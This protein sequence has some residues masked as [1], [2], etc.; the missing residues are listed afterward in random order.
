MKVLRAIVLIAMA[1]AAGLAHQA[2]AATK[3]Y[4][5][6]FCIRPGE[7]KEIFVMLDTDLTD[8]DFITGCLIIPEGLTVVD[9]AYG[10]NLRMKPAQNRASG[11]FANYN[12]EGYG[13]GGGLFSLQGYNACITGTKGPLFSMMLKADENFKFGVIEPSLFFYR[14]KGAPEVSPGEM[15]SGE[16][17]VPSDGVR[18]S[19]ATNLL[20]IPAGQTR[21]VDVMIENSEDLKGLQADFFATGGL[22][23][24]AVEKGSGM[25]DGVFSYEPSTGRL[26]A[27]GNISEGSG[28]VLTVS[29]TADA[30]FKGEGLVGIINTVATN[31]SATAF[32]AE[33]T[34]V[35]L[36]ADA[37]AVTTVNVDADEGS[38]Y[39][40]QGR[41]T[42]TARR[43]VYIKDGRQILVK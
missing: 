31:A 30:T 25:G 24:S 11:F 4:V 21:T 14:Q 1:T 36:N 40:L 35:R 19:F 9:D 12:K 13:Y 15:E 41:R 23:V 5:Q 10:K 26:I 7:V 2:A 16:A 38:I 32:Y 29:I 33:E 28:V 43:G 42:A 3:L 20:T 37:T 27:M 34:G 6:N 17:R 18:L 8:I 22:T 39:D